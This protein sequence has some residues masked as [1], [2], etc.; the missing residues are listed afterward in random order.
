[1]VQFSGTWVRRRNLREGYETRRGR[2]ARIE[3]LVP[4]RDHTD[5]MQFSSSWIF[6][7]PD[8]A[9][10]F[11]RSLKG[12]LKDEFFRIDIPRFDELD[13]TVR[14]GGSVTSFDGEDGVYG[15][16]RFAA[17]HRMSANVVVSASSLRDQGP[18]VLLHR[19]E[20]LAELLAIRLGAETDPAHVRA[21]LSNAFQHALAWTQ[22]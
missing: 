2:A 5:I 14:L 21:R 7:G 3:C 8:A 4:S 16:R 18:V 15:I 9:S 11:P 1:M 10:M 17:Q 12:T 20:E 19:L 13:L 6:G 22:P